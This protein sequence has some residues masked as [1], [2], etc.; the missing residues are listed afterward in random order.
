M[1]RLFEHRLPDHPDLTGRLW[2]PLQCLVS[3]L[4]HPHRTTAN[5]R[6]TLSPSAPAVES[7][8]GL[9]QSGSAALPDVHLQ[10]GCTLGTTHLAYVDRKISS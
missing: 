10:S 8:R 9:G 1:G 5:T 7:D 2:F 6:L 3:R 4:Y